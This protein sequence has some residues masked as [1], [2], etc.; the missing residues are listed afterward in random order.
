[1]FPW[2][3]WSAE[4]LDCFSFGPPENKAQKA[5]AAVCTGLTDESLRRNCSLFALFI[6]G[7][8]SKVGEC[9]AELESGNPD[10]RLGMFAYVSS[11]HLGGCRY[12]QLAIFWYDLRNIGML[13]R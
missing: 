7:Q 9:L 3:L 10:Q 11:S 2:A 12:A 13:G 1:M 4:Y 5:I 6:A 8:L